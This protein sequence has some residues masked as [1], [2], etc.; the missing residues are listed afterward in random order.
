MRSKR[1]PI[2]S[3]PAR[4]R[5]ASIHRDVPGPAHRAKPQTWCRARA[6]RLVAVSALAFAAPGGA[7]AL[8]AS[9]H[10][11]SSPAKT[12][13]TATSTAAGG[14]GAPAATTTAPPTSTY[15]PPGAGTTPGAAA[16]PGAATTP[17]ATTTPGAATTVPTVSAPATTAAPAGAATTPQ[18]TQPAGAAEAG[19]EKG[20]S[21]LSGAAIAIAAAAAL[22]VLGCIAW[23]LA[24]R[25]AFEPHWLLSLRHAMAEA[26]FR[27]SATW[28]EFA[29]WAR[30]GR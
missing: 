20:D 6:A 29:D 22:L 24:R 11:T 13:S 30:L 7:D 14:V 18:Q 1:S 10:V 28:S 9:P 15:V 25:R 16:T 3:R 21:G 5:A 23:A 17:G 27:A 19:A 12:Q 4:P 8:A 2:C 26:G